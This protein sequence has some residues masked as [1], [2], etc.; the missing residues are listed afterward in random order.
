MS[1]TPISTKQIKL[2]LGICKHVLILFYQERP[3]QLRLRPS[4]RFVTN[5]VKIY[6]NLCPFLWDLL[7]L[8]CIIALYIS[9]WLFV[10][11]IFYTHLYW[12]RLPH[13][14]WESSPIT[15]NILSATKKQPREPSAKNNPSFIKERK[16]ILTKCNIEDQRICY[17]CV[18]FKIK[19]MLYI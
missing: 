17:L 3:L 15:P 10:C 7:V 16:Y 12:K 11:L 2:I 1:M 14:E 13:Y 8:M 5:F 9:T 19:K 18:R 4:Y 6:T